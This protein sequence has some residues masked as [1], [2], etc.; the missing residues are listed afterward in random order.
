MSKNNPKISNFSKKLTLTLEFY[1]WVSISVTNNF[2]HE[3]LI[4]LACHYFGIIKTSSFYF[5]SGGKTNLKDSKNL[6]NY[7]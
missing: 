6:Q 7:C 5:V 1:T 3:I 4:P 2:M